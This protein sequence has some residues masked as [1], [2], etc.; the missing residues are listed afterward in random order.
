MS[1]TVE[2]TPAVSDRYGRRCHFGDRVGRPRRSDLDHFLQ[3]GRGLGP[4]P[5]ILEALRHACLPVRNLRLA[6]LREP[7]CLQ[8]TGP[9]A[10]LQ[11]AV[12]EQAVDR[13]ARVPKPDCFEQRLH[14]LVHLV[15]ADQR[16]REV[17]VRPAKRRIHPDRP[18][19]RLH[20]FVILALFEI[21][22]AE[23][24]CQSRGLGGQRA[25]LQP[26]QGVRPPALLHELLHLHQQPPFGGR[27]G[28]LDPGLDPVTPVERLLKSRI[29]PVF[30][31]QG[32]RLGSL[33]PRHEQQ[34]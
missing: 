7:V 25:R 14:R 32:Q 23:V 4:A 34:W 28:W 27:H 2:S 24:V 10:A 12:T 30:P 29:T 16:H 9:L 22:V 26:L 15:I 18:P 33:R 21:Q 20:C 11:A 31:R 19:K 5:K 17:P 6:D 8:G 13:P 3:Q 1:G